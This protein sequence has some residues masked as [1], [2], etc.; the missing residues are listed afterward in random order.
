M[1]RSPLTAVLDLAPGE[2]AF[3]VW[4]LL[5]FFL[6][7]TTFWIL[8]PLKKSLFVEFYSEGGFRLG[9]WHLEAAE[10]ELV[11]K[12]L[13][14]AVAAA[15]MVAFTLL[16]RRLRRHRLSLALAAAFV[17][18]FALYAQA[19]HR[20]G[21]A[22]VWSFYL[23]GDL[24]S[25][26]M[27]AGFFAFLNDTVSADAAKRLYGPIGLGG[28]AGGVLGSGTLGALV[29]RLAAPAWVHV[30]AELVL[31]IA[32]VAW[33]AGRA[34]RAL[35]PESRSRDRT[36]AP[37]RS[38]RS[39]AVEGAALV[40]R[41]SYLLSIVA[42]VGLY[43]IV[44]TVMDFQ[45]TSTVTHYREGDAIGGHLSRVFAVTNMVSLLVQV[46]LTGA[47]MSRL[48]VGVALLVLPGAALAASAAFLVRPTLWVGSALN[49]ADNGFS[50]SIN[51]SAKE[52]L[53]V[54]TSRAERYQAKAFI[55]MFVQRGAKTI[56]IAASLGM[57][58]WFAEF[59]S[60]RWLSL[61]SMTVI[62]AWVVAARAA[63]R[64]FRERGGSGDASE[65]EHEP[66]AGVP[67]RHVPAHG[68]RAVESPLVLEEVVV[69]VPRMREEHRLA[70][71]DAGGR[72]APAAGPI[73][74][75]LRDDQ[76][77]RHVEADV[78]RVPRPGPA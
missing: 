54:P 16:A 64:G 47:V 69:R 73:A 6:V 74:E 22:A 7:T 33:L 75:S 60:I 76:R 57:S 20:P 30:S 41:S 51:Q 58:Q 23:V 43:E 40:L 77:P 24:F 68:I 9:A 17:A 59:A 50:Y 11:A 21:D 18:T 48:G 3:T 70:D 14:M 13:N 15:A 19:L 12:F 34:A 4:M 25:T 45:F 29:E 55:D 71:G 67:G 61:V 31:V 78:R 65:R 27:V 5:Y 35:P 37:A 32:L 8:K 42:I 26:V 53:Y 28:V 66:R 10:A 44:S 52:A 56:G 72:G 2:R 49:T 46:F 38:R 36:D 1:R 62:L 63:G 39:A